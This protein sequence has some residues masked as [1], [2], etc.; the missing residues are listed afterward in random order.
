MT[1]NNGQAKTS[2]KQIKNILQKIV[3]EIGKKWKYKIHDAYRTTYK[4]PIG[5]SP[6]HLVCGQTC[7]LHV[8]LEFKADWAIKKWNMDLH[9]AGKNHQM[10]ISALEEWREK[11]YHNY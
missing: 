7:H 10:Q 2:N 4:T 9:L 6:Y 11:A 1:V 5:M 8:E 3:D